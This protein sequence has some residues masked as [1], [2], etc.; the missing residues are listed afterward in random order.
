MTKQTGKLT[1]FLERKQIRPSMKVYFIDAMG[2][3]ALGLF[4]TLLMS[5]ILGTVADLIFEP[6]ADKKLWATADFLHQIASYASSATGMAIGVAM[7]YALKAPP[8]VIYSCAVVGAMANSMGATIDGTPYSAGPA[9]IFFVIILACELGKVVSKETKVDILVT[10]L[11]VLLTG[12][13]ASLLI[14]PA[15]AYVMYYLGNFISIATDFAPLLM[16][17]VVSA[18]MGIVLTLPISSAAICAVVFSD[19]VIAGSSSPEALYL[20]AGAAAVGC[21]CQMVGFAVISFRENKFGG[22]V[23]QGLGTSMLQMGNIIRKPIIWVPAIFASAVCGALSTTLFEL[24]CAGVFAGMGTCGV[25]GPIG[26]LKYSGSSATVWVG[27][28]LLCVVLPALLSF[29]CN[30]LLRKLGLVKTGDMKIDV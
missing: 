25:V 22:L 10:P 16:G 8:L 14:C 13:G 19:T 18:V 5:T 21:C 9:G 2:A 26:I 15:V 24:K 17:I 28:I 7:A 20:A 27:L 3:M 6:I 23:A 30:E 29:A 12:Y 11:T 1:A 4:A